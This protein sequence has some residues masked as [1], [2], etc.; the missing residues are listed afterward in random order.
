MDVPHATV[1]PVALEERQ[2]V[3]VALLQ[4]SHKRAGRKMRQDQMAAPTIA[5]VAARQGRRVARISRMLAKDAYEAAAM[6]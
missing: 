4:G 6:A 1:V 5:S 3:S 2:T